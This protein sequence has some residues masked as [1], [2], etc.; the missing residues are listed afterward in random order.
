MQSADDLAKKDISEKRLSQF[1]I[2]HQNFEKLNTDDPFLKQLKIF[3]T[4]LNKL[5]SGDPADYFK[6]DFKKG[7]VTDIK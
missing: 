6:I 3:F 5:S 7:E 2:L 4:I 1:K